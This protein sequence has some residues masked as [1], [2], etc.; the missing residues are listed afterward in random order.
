MSYLLHS[1]TLSHSVI[2][3]TNFTNEGEVTAQA[4]KERREML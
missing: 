3:A 4:L 1:H 2:P